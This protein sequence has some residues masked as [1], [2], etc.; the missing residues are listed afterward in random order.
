MT[1]SPAFRRTLRGLAVVLLASVPAA[2]CDSGIL[3]VTDPDVIF[4]ANSAAGAQ[5]LRNGVILRLAQAVSGVQGPDALFVYGGL[6][7]DEWRSGDT[8]VQRNNQDQ[9]IWD[10]QNTFNAGP[11]RALNRVRVESQNAVVA[12]RKY[13][14]ADS[15]FLVGQMFALAAYVEVLMGEHYCNGTPISSVQGTAIQFGDPISND[16]MFAL[17]AAT[18]DSALANRAGRDSVRIRSLAL[19]LKARALV[20]RGQ[21]AAAAALVPVTT[22]PDNFVY[23]VTHSTAVNTNQMWSLNNSAK[24]YTMVDV[25]GGAGLDY[26]GANDPR[27]PRATGTSTVVDLIFDSAFPLFV[28]RQGLWGQT[29]AVT[30]ASGVE[31]RLIEAEALLQ[32][33]SAGPWLT[34]INGLRTTTTLYPPVQ[35]GFTRGP[36]LVA[37]ADPGTAAGR[38][39]VMFRERAFWLFGTGHRLGDMRRLMRQYGRTEAQVYPTGPYFKGGAFGNA[40][41][42]S[43]PFDEVNNPN[44]V[45]CTDQL[46]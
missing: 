19:V 1:R 45:Q 18:A 34:L 15:T 26:I 40:L 11:Y 37:L 21:F 43:V 42:L 4:D 12:I 25:E 7:T 35:A 3:E 16:S 6:L 10:P 14:P 22:V 24:R 23:Q 44:F 32:A 13:M 33:G 2:A 46:P 38:E 20:N 28:T 41:M 31:A 8:F 5:A 27:L 29:G 36:N 17:A 30:I 39:D 9:R